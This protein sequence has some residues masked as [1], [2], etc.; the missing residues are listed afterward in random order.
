MPGAVLVD[1]FA[2]GEEVV[3]FA[4]IDFGIPE[5]LDRRLGYEPP[6]RREPRLIAGHRLG[7]VN[8]GM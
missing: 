7:M 1:E 3:K 8:P 4:G 2:L 6:G 5:L